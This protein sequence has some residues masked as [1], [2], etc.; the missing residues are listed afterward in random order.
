MDE[1]RRIGHLRTA[2]EVTRYD[3]MTLHAGANCALPGSL[4][5]QAQTNRVRRLSGKRATLAAS[6]AGLSGCTEA[7]LSITL[8]GFRAGMGGG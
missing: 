1:P 5:Y 7:R 2:L 3:P 4:P 6:E 8:G